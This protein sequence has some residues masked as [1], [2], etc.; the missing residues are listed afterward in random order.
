MK[1]ITLEL[2]KWKNK[3]EVKIYID[4]VIQKSFKID[5]Y[6]EVNREHIVIF[7]TRP[8]GLYNQDRKGNVLHKIKIDCDF[9]T[10]ISQNQYGEIS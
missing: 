9:E 3:G 8:G 5:K 6:Y 2:N 4:D 7:E 10:I 1:R